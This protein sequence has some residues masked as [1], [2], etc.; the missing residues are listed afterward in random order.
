MDITS[1][2]PI[3]K[4]EVVQISSQHLLGLIDSSLYQCQLC[5]VMLRSP[6]PTDE[7]LAQYYDNVP[8]KRYGA[9]Q[10]MKMASDQLNWLTSALME[11][12]QIADNKFDYI[13]IGA[14]EGWL[15]K[16]AE[17][18]DFIQ[19]AIGFEADSKSV[20]W[21][22]TNLG[23][24]LVNQYYN[25]NKSRNAGNENQKILS[26]MHVL[27]HF[28]DPIEFVKSLLAHKT[29]IF[30]YIEVP[31]VK[32]EGDIFKTDENAWGASGQHFWSFSAKSLKILFEEMGFKI[33]KVEA[34]G[35][36]KFWIPTLETLKVIKL[37]NETHHRFQET[38]GGNLTIMKNSLKLLFISASVALKN[39]FRKVN[40][41]DLPSIR[42]LVVNKSDV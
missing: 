14:G 30:L 32:F 16:E 17:K 24:N 2:C 21:G 10:Q 34:V 13:E 19:T 8:S 4:G 18:L 15:T 22:K 25:F 40:R 36:S 37:Y 12:D 29:K 27:E 11:N 26:L 9:K 28:K 7:Q 41:E 23:V 31:D 6:L 39:Q 3:C 38:G 35:N 20:E 5:D 33:L 1:D 42:I